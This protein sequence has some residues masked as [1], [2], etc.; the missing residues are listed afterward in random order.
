[1]WIRILL[2]GIDTA[3]GATYKIAEDVFKTL[4]INY[5]IIGNEPNRS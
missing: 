1:M 5:K 3:N 2:Y 4:G